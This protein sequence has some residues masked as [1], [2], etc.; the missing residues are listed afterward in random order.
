[1]VVLS[2][3]SSSE[4]YSIAVTDNGDGTPVVV[5]KGE[6]DLRAAGEFWDAVQRSL[7]HEPRCLVID[8]A[9][10]SFMDSSGLNVLLRAYNA[11]GE[12]REALVLRA[13]SPPVRRVIELAGVDELVTCE[14]SPP[15]S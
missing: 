12:R 1:M 14:P 2:D 6:I 9:D 5:V 4:C 11:L 7:A 15:P 10:T 8:M 3:S 13:P